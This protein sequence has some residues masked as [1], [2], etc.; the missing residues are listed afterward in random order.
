M[1]DAVRLRA[2]PWAR[3]RDD[4]RIRAESALASDE[5]LPVMPEP[6]AIEARTKVTEG[7]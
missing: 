2:A 6:H 3:E 5:L 4:D 1:R 7:W